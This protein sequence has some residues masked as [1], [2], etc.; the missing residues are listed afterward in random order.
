MRSVDLMTNLWHIDPVRR[1]TA[2]ADYIEADNPEGAVLQLIATDP[3]PDV[4]QIYVDALLETGD[5]GVVSHLEAFLS[6]PD[7]GV[8][9]SAEEAIAELNG[10]R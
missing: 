3:D 2:I 5:P 7:P 9:A 1:D 8:R 10:A 4:R 6:D